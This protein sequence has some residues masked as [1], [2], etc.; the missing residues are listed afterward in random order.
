M[1]TGKA[2]VEFN[3]NDERERD[4]EANECAVNPD[5]EIIKKRYATKYSNVEAIRVTESNAW[6][7]A[8]FLEADSYTVHFVGKKDNYTIHFHNQSGRELRS[9]GIGVWL[10]KQVSIRHGEVFFET[11]SQEDF[12][13]IFEPI[14]ED[15]RDTENTLFLVQ[16][17]LGR[18]LNPIQVRDTISELLNV[19]ILFRE[20]A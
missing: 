16:A 2:Y 5:A 1:A 14:S 6:D 4:G 3:V 12:E 9:V 15:L 17:V 13:R 8:Q 20:R 7:V 11:Y 19:G 18:R 10:T